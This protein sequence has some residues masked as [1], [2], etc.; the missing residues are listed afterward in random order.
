[1][2]AGFYGAT[3]VNVKNDL[4]APVVDSALTPGLAKFTVQCTRS[5]RSL[6]LIS[7]EQYTK[8]SGY[9]FSLFASASL[10]LV[11]M[12]NVSDSR[13]YQLSADAF[14]AIE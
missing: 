11:K 4:I 3:C 7:K 1:M 6:F 13:S 12:T 14:P 8:H 10:S 5:L 2:T 9:G